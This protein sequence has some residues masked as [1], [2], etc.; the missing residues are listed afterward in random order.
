MRPSAG[1]VAARNLR[2]VG[3]FAL[4]PRWWVGHVLALVALVACL[5]LGD[6]QWERSRSVG[7]TGQNLGYALQWP[8]FG[9][10]AVLAWAQFLRL[11]HRRDAAGPRAADPPPAAPPRSAPPRSTPA[12]KDDPDDELAAY[13]AYLAELAERARHDDRR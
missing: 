5:W 2:T 3:R 4:E 9:V 11:E 12:R 10:F 13:N 6:W 8:L 7:G 1:P